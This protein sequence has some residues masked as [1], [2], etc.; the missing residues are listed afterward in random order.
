MHTMAKIQEMAS[1]T[2]ALRLLNELRYH[3]RSQHAC[4]C[5]MGKDASDSAEWHELQ[6]N[7]I[8]NEI[9]ELKSE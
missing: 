1:D 4:H 5:R 6:I 3:L 2:K 8:H 7:R 9:R